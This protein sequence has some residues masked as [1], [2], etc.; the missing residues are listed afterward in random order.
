[1]NGSRVNTGGD[2]DGI[3]E[4]LLTFYE[5]FNRTAD[6]VGHHLQ[7]TVKGRWLSLNTLENYQRMHD[8]YSRVRQS[9]TSPQCRAKNEMCERSCLAIHT[10]ILL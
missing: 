3:Y 1:M 9:S 10:L 2:Y 5:L 8:P 7:R 4:S 6:F